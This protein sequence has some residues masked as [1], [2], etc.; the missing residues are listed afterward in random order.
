MRTSSSSN[1]APLL[2]GGVHLQTSNF[3][4]IDDD[5]ERQVWVLLGAGSEDFD[6]DRDEKHETVPHRVV[7]ATEGE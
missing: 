1:T 5:D 4:C 7:E 3:R 6:G 2:G